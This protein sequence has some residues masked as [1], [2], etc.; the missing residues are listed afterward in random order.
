MQE[1]IMEENHSNYAHQFLKR[2]SP[3]RGQS[4]DRNEFQTIIGLE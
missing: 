3:I 4:I 1:T 2:I